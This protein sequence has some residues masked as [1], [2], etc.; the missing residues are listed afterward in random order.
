MIWIRYTES[1]RSVGAPDA[2]VWRGRGRRGRRGGRARGRDAVGECAARGVARALSR[3][4]AAHSRRHASPSAERILFHVRS[5]S[6]LHV[7]R[8]F[9][10][11]LFLV[12][13]YLLT[14]FCFVVLFIHIF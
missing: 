14:A 7:C 3:R 11:V 4:H 8:A 1:P 13:V 12:Y 5:S 2:R 6:D 9:C 10:R